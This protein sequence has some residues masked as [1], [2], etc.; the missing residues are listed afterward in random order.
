MVDVIDSF[1]G[2]Y[3]FMSNFYASDIDISFVW[4]PQVKFVMPTGEHAFQCLKCV[5]SDMSVDEKMLWLLQ[6]ARA[7]SPNEAKKLGRTI[8]IDVAKWN[9]DSEGFMGRIQQQ[10][11]LQN[12]HLA[13]KLLAT[14]D[15]TLI[16]G[17]DWGDRLWGQ[18]N[19]KGENKLGKIL[20]AVRDQLREQG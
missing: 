2:E 7:A 11:Y 15:A 6:I 13:E 20:M 18:V 10:K 14:G 8:K 9:R 16:E 17:N 5:T 19:G 12:P 3:N 4:A 1:R